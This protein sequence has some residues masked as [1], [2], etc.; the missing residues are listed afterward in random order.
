[1]FTYNNGRIVIHR[2]T[3]TNK[4]N[5]SKEDIMRNNKYND[6]LISLPQNDTGNAKRFLLFCRD[7]VKYNI[8]LQ[9]WMIWNGKLWST[10]NAYAEIIVLAQ[11]VMDKYYTVVKE[12]KKLDNSD[13]KIILSHAKASN[14][15]QSLCD[16]LTL[17]MHMNYIKKMECKPYLLN[18]QNGVVNLK[19]KELLPHHPKYGC[20][21]ICVC[22]YNPNAKSK[23]FKAFVKEICDYDPEE[24]HYVKTAAGYW[25]TG[26]R[27]EEKFFIFLGTGSNGKS[28]YLETIAYTL[29]N[30]AGLFPTTAL[31]KTSQDASKPTPEL[32]PLI[33]TRFAHTSELKSDNIINDACIKQ[34]TGNAHLLVRKMRKEYSIVDIFFKIVVDTNYEPNF[35]RFDDAIKR[36]IVIVPFT[37]KFEGDDRDNDLEQKLQDDA[38]YVLKWLIDGAFDYYANGL[39]EPSIVRAATEM[40]CSESDSVKSFLDNATT[41]QNGC[42]TQSSILYQSYI[43]YCNGNSFEPLDSR[44]FS[45]TLMKKGYEKKLKNSGTFFKNVKLND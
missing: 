22:D 24:Y 1:M 3:K 31:T 33:N 43:E 25:V 44:T 18:V 28:K 14:N 34:Y 10:E 40:Y 41:Y 4:T 35:K 6:Q 23:R 17:V 29:G 13:K 9:E 32:V 36:R 15:R 30:Y 38:V 42:L 21:N 39:H 19:T 8:A 12:N 11:A 37:K 16:T 5:I 7:F 45:Q 27:R 26:S 2:I 20:T